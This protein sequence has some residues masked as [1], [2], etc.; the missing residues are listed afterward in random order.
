MFIVIVALGIGLE[1]LFRWQLLVVFALG[2]IFLYTSRKAGISKKKQR[3]RL[4]LA[5]VFILLAVLLTTS[6]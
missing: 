6:F 2:I 5:A 1:M 4:F 3:N